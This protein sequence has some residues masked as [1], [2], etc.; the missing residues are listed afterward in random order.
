MKAAEAPFK[1]EP[2]PQAPAVLSY[3]QLRKAVGI[4][5]VTLPVVLALGKTLVQGPGLERSISGYYYT[6]LGNVFVGSLCAI[7]VFLIS[8]QG[9]DRKD[10]ISGACAIAAGLLPTTPDA[11]ATSQD[12]LIGALHLTFAG[13]LFVTLAYFC[14]ALFTITSYATPT[15]QKL[16][17]NAFYRF[18][19]WTILACIALIGVVHVPAVK[20]QVEWL[21]PVFYLEAIA[22]M[23]FGAAWLIKG[24]TFLK[25]R[26][27]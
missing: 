11:N 13:L 23:V 1:Q 17:R 8:C 14:L 19:G 22:V 3:L 20:G 16:K 27:I 5:G 12:K 6:D 24:E 2:G 26:A 21:K 4:I 10:E 7:G 9:Y 25:D 18:C 15:P